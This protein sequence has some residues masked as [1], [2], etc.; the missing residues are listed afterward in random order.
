M[1]YKFGSEGG[2]ITYSFPSS[3]RKDRL[4]DKLALGFMT[5]QKYA[6]LARITSGNSDDYIEM[7]LVGLTTN[8]YPAN[9]GLMLGKRCRCWPSVKIALSGS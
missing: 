5:L 9:A 4:E 7:E 1:A 6:V 8:K 2:V 3:E